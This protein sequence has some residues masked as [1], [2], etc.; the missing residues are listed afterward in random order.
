MSLST[1]LYI[2]IYTGGEEEFRI[3]LH[4]SSISH[5]YINLWNDLGLYLTLYKSDGVKAGHLIDSLSDG[6]LSLTDNNL[7]YKDSLSKLSSFDDYDTA[8]TYISDLLN[9]CKL[10][11]DAIVST[12]V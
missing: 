4:Y 5:N 1:E 3:Q 2:D 11:P 6:L 12:S 10:H 9:A 7:L 8:V